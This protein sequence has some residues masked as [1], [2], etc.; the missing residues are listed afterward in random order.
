M[1]PRQGLLRDTGSGRSGHLP[2]PPGTHAPSGR[3]GCR[4]PAG[5]LLP[6]PTPAARPLGGGRYSKQSMAFNELSRASLNQTTVSYFTDF[7]CSVVWLNDQ[8]NHLSN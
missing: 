3:L 8:Q 5:K 2:S 4:S 6:V 1:P 7:S